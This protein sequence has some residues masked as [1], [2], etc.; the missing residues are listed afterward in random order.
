[1]KRLAIAGW[2]YRELAFGALILALGVVGLL[3]I[4]YGAWRPGPGGGNQLVPMVAYWVLAGCG[5][6]IL[7]GRLRAG[8]QPDADRLHVPVVAIVGALLWGVVFFLAVRHI[9]LAVSATVLIGGAMAALSP[10]PELRPAMLALV[11]LAAG[12]VFWLLFTQLAPILVAN[13]I[14]F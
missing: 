7:L 3:D 10:K 12:A 13:P 5:A 4:R 1:M 6:V 11:A 14:L 8:W 9:G 2:R